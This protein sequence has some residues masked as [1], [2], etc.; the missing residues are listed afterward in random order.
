MEKEMKPWEVIKL[1][2]ETPGRNDKIEILKSQNRNH[3]FKYGL[4]ACYDPYVTYGIKQIPE[5][6]EECPLPTE[7]AHQQIRGSSFSTGGDEMYDQVAMALPK[8]MAYADFELV[9]LKSLRSR[10]VTGNAAKDLVEFMLMNTK[11]VDE[12]NYWYRRIL[13]KD[14]KCGITAKTINKAY[15]GNLIKTFGV[16]LASDGTGKEHLMGDSIIENKYDGVRCLAVVN[17]NKVTYY[18]RNGKEINP[19][20][21]PDE[22]HNILNVPELQGLVFDGELMSTTFQELM[23]LLHKKYEIE[24][25]DIYYAIFDVIPFDEFI[26]GE[27]TKTLI[28][29]KLQLTELTRE[30]PDFFWAEQIQL[31]DYNEVNLKQEDGEGQAAKSLHY[32]TTE[33]VKYQFEGIIVKD[34][35]SLWRA[36][37]SNDWLKIKPFVEKSLAV[38][39]IVEGT[40]KNEGRLGNLVCEGI[41]TGQLINTNVGSGFTD[42]QRQEIWDNKDKYM[43]LIAEVRGDCVTEMIDGKHSIRFPR[44]KG[45]RGSKPGEKI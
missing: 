43:G 45:W 24:V 11:G 6:L 8:Y 14:L 15:G 28:E 41:D 5:K 31:I 23:H 4:I 38:I 10:H 33:A 29:R 30:L 18:T 42:E 40:G 32:Y 22:V 13:L 27:S 20:V 37:R 17:K 36:T 44:F 16:Q 19:K 2:E 3:E 34:K 26:K 1:L 25:K 7:V 9:V 21:I 35:N 39:D 12:W